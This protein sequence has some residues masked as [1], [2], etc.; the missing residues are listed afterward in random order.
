MI[1]RIA[2]S[3]LGFM[4]VFSLPGTSASSQEVVI[5][6]V[7]AGECSLTVEADDEWHTLRLRALHPQYRGCHITRGEM[8]SAL[9]TAFL[10]TEA[11]KLTGTYSSLFIGRLIDYP[12]LSQYLAVAA[13]RDAGWNSKRGKPVAAGINTYVSQVLFKRELLADIETILAKAGYRV[14]GVTV[15]KVLVGRFS[16]VPL[17]EGDMVS[18]RVPYDAQVWLRIE[19]N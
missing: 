17:Y 19:K 4:L 7:Q 2:S 6:S 5:V 13:S 11:P 14:V 15:E 9:S 3:I 10:K 8:V 18:G 16:E 12:W 1:R